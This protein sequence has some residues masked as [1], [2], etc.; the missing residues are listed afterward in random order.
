[1]G[2]NRRPGKLL[3]NYTKLLASVPAFSGKFFTTT[4]ALCE[5]AQK[6]MQ[7]FLYGEEVSKIYFK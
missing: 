7:L 2:L 1:M 6:N 4:M 5:V 3:E